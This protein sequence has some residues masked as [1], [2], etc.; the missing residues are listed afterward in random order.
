[1]DTESL[2]YRMIP[3]FNNNIINN[4]CFLSQSTS[5][6]SDN[7]KH[8]IKEEVDIQ[9]SV[10][11]TKLFTKNNEILS[12]FENDK[13]SL[14]VSTTS[15]NK[16]SDESI[17]NIKSV[18]PNYYFKRKVSMNRSS[19]RKLNKSCSLK[20]SFYALCLD[21]QDILKNSISNSKNSTL[22]RNL[23]HSYSVYSKSIEEDLLNLEINN[24]EIASSF[25]DNDFTSIVP[26]KPVS[27][28]LSTIITTTKSKKM[29]KKDE[30]F[31]FFNESPDS[32]TDEIAD[33][34]SLSD[35]SGYYP[36]ELIILE[37][38]TKSTGIALNLNETV[39]I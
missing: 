10:D 25:L 9:A 1:M 7:C 36:K 16:D 31:E 5:T 4:N 21:N 35:E 13:C 26:F 22:T 23:N 39:K 37:I 11:L 27:Y 34:D 15:L 14:R 19:V 24:L 38:I 6:I 8:F 33:K 30:S 12:I 3:I 20:K 2:C 18:E 28:I 17:L 32:E 29:I